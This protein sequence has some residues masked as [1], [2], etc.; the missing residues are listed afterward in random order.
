MPTVST[1]PGAN[2]HNICRG[3][4]TIGYRSEVVIAISPL[5]FTELFL[6][7]KTPKLFE[8]ADEHQTDPIGAFYRWSSIKWYTEYADV[9]DV[10]AYLRTL[11]D[12]DYG[13]IRVGEGDRDIEILGDPYAYGI[14]AQTR[15]ACEVI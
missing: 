3:V 11:D 7:Q 9:V 2:E 4:R 8:E 14:Y 13:F 12:E 5:K 15:I 6:L 10:L 1:L